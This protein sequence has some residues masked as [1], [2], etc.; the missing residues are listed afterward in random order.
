[1]TA[2]RT[3][4]HSMRPY[5]VA[6]LL[7]ASALTGQSQIPG[8]RS[9]L[10]VFGTVSEQTAAGEAHLL[11]EAAHTLLAGGDSVQLWIP[12]A[13]EPQVFTKFLKPEEL[14][15]ALRSVAKMAA[16][17]EPKTFLNDMDRATFALK[18][19]SGK[20]VLVVV[21]DAGPHT[22]DAESRLSGT[23]GFCKENEIKVLL[24]GTSQSAD[25]LVTLATDSG[26][27]VLADSGRFLQAAASLAPLTKPD[28]AAA[29]KAA[30]DSGN[31]GVTVGMMRTLPSKGSGKEMMA[32]MGLLMVETP[33][34]TLDF[35]EAGRN[36][37]AHARVSA[38]IRN[39]GGKEV[40]KVSKEISIKGPYN[41]LAARKKGYLCFMRGIPLPAGTY[42]VEGTVEDL[43]TGKSRS[44]TEP[45]KAADSLPGFDVSDAQIV[46]F[47]D[48]AV[49]KFEADETFS[50]DSKALSPLVN[51]VFPANQPFTLQVYFLVYPDYRGAIPEM[52]LNILHDGQSVGHSK[53]NFGDRIRNTSTEGS[54]M[55]SAGEQKREFPYLANLPDMRLD[56]GNYEVRV[57]VKQGR[58]TAVRV[59][60]FSVGSN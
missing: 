32:M 23:A 60:R 25:P 28:A 3:F 59:T 58:N 17:S 57:T 8:N 35:Q 22:E 14:E 53:L 45:I 52:D 40:S 31:T 16:A 38:T 10:F 34:D 55:E 37:L 20:R 44:A 51:P 5:F 2:F 19:Q 12:G 1:M 11:A 54:S 46:R 4:T 39:A 26:G 47:L 6:C 49:D 30:N 15:K 27:A 48:E 24:L 56:A 18:R 43:N 29:A 9:F 41:K 13:R 33:L 50:F 7:F 21:A 42:T 36:Y